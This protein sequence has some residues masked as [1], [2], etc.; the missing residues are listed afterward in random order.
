ML[1]HLRAA[2][3]NQALQLLWGMQGEEMGTEGQSMC[4]H[5]WLGDIS[6]RASTSVQNQPL[7]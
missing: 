6:P 5:S 3:G 7:L 4:P 1:H 2:S